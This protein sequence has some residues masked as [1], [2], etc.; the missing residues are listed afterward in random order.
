MHFKYHFQNFYIT[1]IQHMNL[2]GFYTVSLIQMNILYS[3]KVTSKLK[4]W[5][6]AVYSFI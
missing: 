4:Y 2:S 6:G 3:I 1:K 5:D